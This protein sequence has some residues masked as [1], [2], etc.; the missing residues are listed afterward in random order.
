MPAQNYQGGEGRGG[1]PE[2]AH[3]WQIW[4]VQGMHQSHAQPLTAVKMYGRYQDNYYVTQIL[5][6]WSS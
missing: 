6:K 2:R 5:M 3:Y 4:P 1:I